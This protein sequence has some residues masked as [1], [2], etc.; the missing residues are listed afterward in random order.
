[1]P[2]IFFGHGSPLNAVQSNDW[3]RA[4]QSIGRTLPR[5]R[6]IV[7]VSAHWYLPGTR[8]TAMERP[9]TIHD[10]RGFPPELYQ[11]TYPAAGEPTLARHLAACSRR[12]RWSSTRNGV[13]ITGRG[14]CSDTC[15]PRLTC[16]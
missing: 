9:P 5:P 12:S 14:Q 4:W 16:R 13:S 11:I 10:F 15:S 1:M 3:T 2:A 8:V 6:A 7:A